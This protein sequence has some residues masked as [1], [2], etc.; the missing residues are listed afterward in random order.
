M[1]LKLSLTRKSRLLIYLLAASAIALACA[2][3]STY[4]D[5]EDEVFLMPDIAD[6]SKQNE[7]FF[8]T[9]NFI[10][11]GQDEYGWQKRE[12]NIANLNDQNIDEWYEYFDGKISKPSID[13]FLYKSR[14]FIYIG[15]PTFDRFIAQF[16]NHSF[17]H[18]LIKT[19]N[20]TALNYFYLA[21]CNEFGYN[22][23]DN[24]WNSFNEYDAYKEYYSEINSQNYNPEP[25]ILNELKKSKNVFFQR[26]LAF[27]LIRNYRYNHY[28][29]KVDSLFHLYFNEN[30][31]DYLFYEALNYTCDAETNAGHFAK[32]NYYASILFN[33]TKSK[34]FKAYLNFT[35]ATDIDS[36]LPYANNDKQKSQI[37]TLYSFHDYYPNTLFVTKAVEYD[38]TNSNINDLIIREIN[39]L[40]YK[41]MPPNEWREQQETQKVV[42]DKN[43]QIVF[44]YPD[45]ELNSNKLEHLLKTL[46]LKHTKQ[47]A[48]YQLCLGHLYIILLKYNDANHILKEVSIDK[49]TDKQRAQ[50]Y[51][52]TT[53]LII[54]SQNIRAIETRNHLAK[55]I[56][57]I[58]ENTELYYNKK[59][60]EQG[61]RLLIQQ[62]LIKQKDF[63][64]AYL[65]GTSLTDQFGDQNILNNYARPED[66]DTINQIISEPK[67]A[68]DEF[69]IQNYT[70][71]TDKPNLFDVQGSLYLRA[72]K[73]TDAYKSFSKTP[74]IYIPIN[75][76]TLNTN[77]DGN[78]FYP[79]N[80]DT[81]TQEEATYLKPDELIFFNNRARKLKLHYNN[82]SIT[83]EMVNIL[84][85]IHKKEGNMGQ[86]YFNLASLYIEISY[87]GRAYKAVDFED[88]WRMGEVEYLEYVKLK[89]PYFD[90]YY[91]CK[92]AIHFYKLALAS[93]G[94]NEL[95]AKCLYALFR[96][97]RHRQVYQNEQDQNDEL[98]YLFTL[99]DKYSNTEY[100]RIKECWGLSAYVKELREE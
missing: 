95:K 86:N 57:K 47:E 25:L 81:L 63:A 64:R 87:Y 94:N 5:W 31:K 37:Y 96:C 100:F 4:W 8:Y 79:Y 26:R 83:K 14:D 41:L 80:Y 35:R 75:F 85:R 67:G 54:K 36:V 90:N 70:A 59:F 61:I 16:R 46:I 10:N 24:G 84:R 74:N 66:I 78:P 9:Q 7:L 45:S 82:Y 56:G 53:L 51:L 2:D 68:F 12:L 72:D 27:Q 29:T 6:S 60:V 38:E 71:I 76:S 91:G 39:K 28:N 21:K 50:Y 52:T 44:K 92:Q 23:L 20:K 49:L 22:K 98:K 15:S 77:P 73:I 89:Q 58:A 11:V 88:T 17:I 55:A 40:D 34:K 42:F 18:W 97:T 13:S 65:M 3:F 99:N 93:A 30:N 19:N 62:E 43:E 69:L 33:E 32:A 1:K 48:F